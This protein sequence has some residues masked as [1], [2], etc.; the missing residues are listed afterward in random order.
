MAEIQK[1]YLPQ[2]NRRHL[3]IIKTENV[4]DIIHDLIIHHRIK[5]FTPS[6]RHKSHRVICDSS[7][8]KKSWIR[9]SIFMLKVREDIVVEID[10]QYIV[11]A[12]LYG[13]GFGV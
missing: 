8:V 5:H 1:G 9:N 6:H 13:P 3:Q 2:A 12:F 4:E 10:G 7:F 11:M